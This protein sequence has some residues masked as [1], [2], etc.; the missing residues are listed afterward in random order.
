MRVNTRDISRCGVDN[1]TLVWSFA[2]GIRGQTFHVKTLSEITQLVS[3][4]EEPSDAV[5]FKQLPITDKRIATALHVH[6][7]EWLSRISEIS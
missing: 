3:F 5:T 4:K 1:G 7:Q 2:G 6:A